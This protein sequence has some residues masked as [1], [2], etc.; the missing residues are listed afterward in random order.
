[1]SNIHMPAPPSV[2]EKNKKGVF[3]E[4]DVLFKFY[5]CLALGFVSLQC[6]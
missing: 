4:M 3:K 6:V 1:M 5:E 2:S